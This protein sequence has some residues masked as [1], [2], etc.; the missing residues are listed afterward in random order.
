VRYLKQQLERR[1]P[2]AL[3]VQKEKLLQERYRRLKRQNAELEASLFPAEE[4]QI[5]IEM[6]LEAIDKST[7]ALHSRKLSDEL[8]DMNEPVVVRARLK[9]PVRACR[10]DVYDRLQ[11]TG[12]K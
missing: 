2:N 3:I 7:K 6:L 5:V 12:E 11:G 10:Q 8:A 9:E 1:A 4:A